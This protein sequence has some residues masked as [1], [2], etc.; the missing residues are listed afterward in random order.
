MKIFRR[1][2]LAIAILVGFGI[3]FY[4]VLRGSGSGASGAFG[5]TTPSLKDTMMTAAYGFTITLLGVTLGALYRRLIKLRDQGAERVPIFETLV[6]ALTSTDFLL[7]IVGSPV[8]FGLL[9]QAISTMP[10]AG[11]TIIALQNGFASHAIVDQLS[12]GGHPSLIL[13]AKD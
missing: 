7:G 11:I 12:S 9:W 6:G 2:C 4:F 8:V 13:P 5:G 3:T 1:V 10:L